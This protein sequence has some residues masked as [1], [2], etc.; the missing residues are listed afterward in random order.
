MVAIWDTHVSSCCG[1]RTPSA[2]ASVPGTCDGRVLSVYARSASRGAAHTTRNHHYHNSSPPTPRATRIQ[3][4][5]AC[6]GAQAHWQPEARARIMGHGTRISKAPHC[7][8]ASPPRSLA[9][10]NR[11]ESPSR[12][13]SFK[14]G[15]RA[16][17]RFQKPSN[18]NRAKFPSLMHYARCTSYAR[19]AAGRPSSAKCNQTL[20]L[21]PW[22]WHEGRTRARDRLKT[23]YPRFVTRYVAS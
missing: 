13:Q 8:L 1:S 4:Y 9:T 14:F 21:A 3:D 12:V 16:F 2:L 17:G 23:S 19:A 15:D 20:K 11:S 10:W 5:R 6:T 18:L 22:Q 7:D